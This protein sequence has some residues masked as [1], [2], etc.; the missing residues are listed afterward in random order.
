MAHD[1]WNDMTKRNLTR[2]GIAQHDN[3]YNDKYDDDDNDDN[4]N[5]YSRA[6]L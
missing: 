3:I 4:E 6:R 2:I 5:D 1:R